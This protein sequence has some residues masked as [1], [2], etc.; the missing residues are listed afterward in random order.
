M[1]RGTTSTTSPFAIGSFSEP[2]HV[3]Y[4]HVSATLYQSGTH[5]CSHKG[6]TSLP[7]LPLSLSPSPA[8]ITTTTP[9]AL[10]L[11]LSSSCCRR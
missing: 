8:A 11:S 10:F 4:R 5:Y 6:L 3:C 9:R 1:K 7:S 2:S